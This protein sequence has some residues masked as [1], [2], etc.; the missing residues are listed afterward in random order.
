MENE[1]LK[2]E[3]LEIWKQIKGYEGLYEVSNFG[4][5]KSLPRLI[6][7]AQVGEGYYTKEKIKKPLKYV[8]KRDNAN[9][10]YY[11]IGLNKD[12][13]CTM[14][15]IHRLLAEAFI[16]NPDGKPFINHIDGNGLNNH[17]S[18]LEWCTHSEN[19][20]HAVKTGLKSRTTK[21]GF[22]V[23]IYKNGVFVAAAK[24]LTEA[25]KLLN[26]SKPTVTRYYSK[27]H[28]SPEG[29]EIRDQQIMYSFPKHE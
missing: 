25:A 26:K 7:F 22:P 21:K 4:R 14:F 29:Y 10:Q 13:V 18:N 24:N 9:A 27:T 11:N 19:Q 6:K 15:R 8:D 28:I 16:P 3:G 5:I 2:T 17:V 20:K 23:E 12:G 1:L